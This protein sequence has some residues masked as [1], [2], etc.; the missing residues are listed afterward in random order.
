METKIQPAYYAVIPADVRYSDIMPNAKLLYGEITA[1]CN[2][3]GYCWATNAYFCAL[4]KV[5]PTTI[6]EWVKALKD[7]GFIDVEI[8]DKTT[9]RLYL[10]LREKPKGVSGKAEAHPS[11]KAEDNNTS[12]NTKLNTTTRF[13]EFWGLYP[14]KTEKKKAEAKWNR[15]GIKIQDTILADLPKR[16]ACD[17]WK[18]GFVPN[19]MTYLNGERW[20]DDIPAEPQRAF[21]KP[22]YSASP[23]YPNFTRQRLREEAQSAKDQSQRD[24]ATRQLKILEELDRRRDGLVK[25]M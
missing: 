8:L 7:A 24:E 13:A 2:K 5:A 23:S 17:Q 18:R 21:R 6:S 11:G 15:L 25:S 16:K 19:P 9:R 1:L 20:N 22:E 4:Y 14:K 10:T 3:E 12:I